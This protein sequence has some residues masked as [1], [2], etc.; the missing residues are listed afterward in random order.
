MMAKA[1]RI[2]SMEGCDKKHFG[3]GLCNSHY[4]RA[5]RSG[6]GIP[7]ASLRTPA[8]SVEAWLRAHVSWAGDDCLQFPFC[9]NWKGYGLA[10]FNGRRTGAHRV[11]CELA[12]GA[13]PCPDM[14]AGHL[15][16]K[17]HLGCVNPRHLAW[18][19]QRENQS[20]KPRRLRGARH[21]KAKLGPV[22]V[23]GAR[24]MMESMTIARV[25]SEFGV[26]QSTMGEIKHRQK[27]THI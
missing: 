13:A 23:I 11:M 16:H 27:W 3:R 19:T 5:K 7:E 14:Q 2:C 4:V 21:H 15:C 9:R 17:G 1:K 24:L 8:G 26:S 20:E 18:M 12:H 10:T 6:A 25:A 22:D